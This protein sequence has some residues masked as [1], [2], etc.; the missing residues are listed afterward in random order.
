MSTA[1]SYQFAFERSLG[2]SAPMSGTAASSPQKILSVA[3]QIGMAEGVGAVG[4]RAVA[5]AADFSSSAVS[6]HFQDRETLLAALHRTVQDEHYEHLSGMLDAVSGMPPH[7]RSLPGFVAAVICAL[8]HSARQQTLL[9]LELN[10]NAA[11]AGPL[12]A[13]L[14][15][16]FWSRVADRFETAPDAIWKWRILAE[17]AT[18][19]ALLDRDPVVS[20]TWLTPLTFRFES[21]L[22]GWR[23]PS[24]AQEAFDV[25]QE[26]AVLRD[27]FGLDPRPR[28]VEITEA[29][30]R[31][32]SRYKPISHRTIAKEA[33]VP[34]A[35]TTYFFNGKDDILEA[36]Y[37]SIYR[38]LLGES[39]DPRACM[40]D[41]FTPDGDIK[42]PILLFGRLILALA[43]EEA[44]TSLA[45]GVRNARGRSSMI[46][47]RNRGAAMDRLDGLLWSASQGSLTPLVLSQPISERDAFFRKRVQEL[48]FDLFG[49]EI[50][51]HPAGPS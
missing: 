12:S 18:L 29:A 36:A 3:R 48:A 20:T 9:L 47:L 49:V 13:P 16:S 43:R 19:F 25:D 45:E 40:S 2:H 46:A 14:A 35:A 21:R 51:S 28:A 31:L 38:R 37:R 8:A 26:G 10:L 42:E 50:E 22:G 6:Y 44:F 1:Q 23:S 39:I 7:M 15:E 34:L 4:V 30:V 27:E 32:L 41:P 5:R 33:G 24:R 17:S 11:T